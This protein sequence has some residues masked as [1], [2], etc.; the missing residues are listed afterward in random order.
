MNDDARSLVPDMA[1]S[2]GHITDQEEEKKIK[3]RVYI[4]H[5]V[6]AAESLVTGYRLL[7]DVSA[8]QS[9]WMGN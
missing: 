2:G 9:R 1:A 8:E 3:D 4:E 7:H 5:T 6:R